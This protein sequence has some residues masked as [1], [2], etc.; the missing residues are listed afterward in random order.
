MTTPHQLDDCLSTAYHGQILNGRYSQALKDRVGACIK[1]FHSLDQLGSPIIP[2]ISAWQEDG[3]ELW[4]EFCGRKLMELLHCEPTA[5]A[6]CLR[7]RLIVR[8]AYRSAT[9]QHPAS[10]EI[11][12]QH[13]LRSISQE[14]RDQVKRSGTIEAIYKIAPTKSSSIW[15]KDQATVESFP[16][17]GI[18][19]SLGTLCLLSNEM[20]AEELLSQNH[21]T[22]CQH[23]AK[24]G[25][26]LQN[27]TRE[28]HLAQ[29]DIISRL[30][31]AAELRDQCT[32]EH[33]TKMSHYCATIGQAIGVKPE[34]NDLL[35]HATPMHDVG[36]I[37]ISDNIL[38]KP[39]KL[40][41]SEFQIM[42]QHT[43]I[44]AELLSGH[45]SRLLKV[46]KHIA[47]AHHERWDGRGYPLGLRQRE[48]SLPGR[49]T[50]LC[51]VFDALT[52][53]RPY[54]EAW[55][56]DKAVKEIWHGKGNHFDPRLV[57]VFIKQ[58][59]TIK[60]IYHQKIAPAQ[61]FAALTN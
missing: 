14:L 60:H 20:E 58:L 7:E 17:E 50:A 33:I 8:Y 24:I 49:I 56:F 3:T 39:G 27:K 30:A 55:P 57:D 2:Y 54:K 40:T 51:D 32:G 61:P 37:G 22:L 36:K 4:H 34:L 29:L 42:K 47:L 52:S 45:S 35:F 10:K 11:L 48:I 1:H 53:P 6:T 23:R 13:T 21:S 31:K 44:G 18:F 5:V 9:S 26:L 16:A 59:P 46:A 19:L 43:N 41:S 38:L 28:L 12:C 15:L 25:Q